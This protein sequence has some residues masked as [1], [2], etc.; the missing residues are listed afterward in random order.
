MS[1]NSGTNTKSNKLTKVSSGPNSGVPT[2]K[3]IYPFTKKIPRLTLN[4][5]HNHHSTSKTNY[6]NKETI[7]LNY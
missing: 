6:L 2:N 5:F 3:T 7:D 4:L 1:K